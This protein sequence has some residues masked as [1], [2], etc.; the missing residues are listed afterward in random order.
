MNNKRFG[1]L[2]N[3]SENSHYFYDSGTGKV[4]NCNNEEKN[5]INQILENKISLEE[6]CSINSEF[7]NFII[8]ENLFSCPEYRDFLIPEKEELKKLLKGNCEQLI[9]EVTESCNLRCGY[10]VYNDHHPNF[11]GFSNR[12][13]KFEVAKKT[14]D[15]L[16]KDYTGNRFAL[17]FYG[18]EPL[19][20]FKL[21]KQCIDYTKETYPNVKLDVSFTTNLT[22]LTKEMIDYFKTIDNIYILCS[23][24]GP[25]STHNKYRRYANGKG[26]FNDA[27]KG[28]HL[29]LD[30]FYDKN[31][32]NRIIAINSVLVP[33]Y[34]KEKLDELNNF[35][36]KEL[37]LPKDI[38]CNYSYL[39]RG[40]MV[41]DFDKNEIISPEVS[42]KLITSPLE[43]WAVDNF[44]ND[45]DYDSRDFSFV[46]KDMLKIA[47]RLK[48][49][50]GVIEST[51]LQGNCIPGKR[52][53]YVTVDGT[54]RT[55]ERVGDSPSLGNYEIGYDFDKIYKTYF[56][57]YAN[58]FKEKC[59]NCWAQPLCSLCY[60]NTMCREG[61]KES[62]D[63]SGCAGSRNIIKDAFI[64]YYR[65][66]ET[67]R[68]LL[69]K[70]LRKYEKLQEKTEGIIKYEV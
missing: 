64:N 54:F 22:L 38:T 69:E 66:L 7:K 46:S 8:S 36:Y 68:E 26:T 40:E 37:N 44:I 3:T 39:D 31:N 27:I 25:E 10:C 33:P 56:V 34:N 55:C 43:E 53:L 13:M 59:K 50:D 2:F 24:D 41:F 51:F 14:I 23:I 35:F 32:P 52:R 30:T 28:L 62:A 60:Q 42:K 4:V 47:K 19:F 63:T 16:L 48:V 45:K 58:H 21:I 61:I 6:A 70:A 18:G 65:L 57:D 11:R 12:V 67:D 29:L 20:N 1:M 15:Y 9:L 5:L 17:T 49:D